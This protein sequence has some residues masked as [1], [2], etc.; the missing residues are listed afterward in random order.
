[1][2]DFH[3]EFFRSR[4]VTLQDG[5]DS[6][7]FVYKRERQGKRNFFPPSL[8]SLIDVARHPLEFQKRGKMM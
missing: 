4:Q 8:G 7:T 6:D 3:I 2:N 5:G 1:M